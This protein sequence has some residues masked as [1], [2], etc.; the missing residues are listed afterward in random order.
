M[1]K[2][3]PKEQEG[4]GYLSSIPSCK[5]GSFQ[6]DRPVQMEG[7]GGFSPFSECEKL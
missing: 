7:D 3:A 2:R 1:P 5:T 6:P 4:D